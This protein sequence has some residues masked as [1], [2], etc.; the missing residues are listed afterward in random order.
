MLDINANLNDLKSVYSYNIR[1]LL[2][3]CVTVKEGIVIKVTIALVCVCVRV[4]G[5]GGGHQGSRKSH[6]PAEGGTIPK[7]TLITSP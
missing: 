7:V 5:R 1:T 6:T 4:L 2:L 3:K